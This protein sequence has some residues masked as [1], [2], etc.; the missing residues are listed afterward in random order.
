MSHFVGFIIRIYVYYFICTLLLSKQRNPL[1]KIGATKYGGKKIEHFD[2]IGAF[3]LLFPFLIGSKWIWCAL[4]FIDTFCI[5]K[6][7][8][9]VAVEDYKPTKKKKL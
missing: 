9:S 5:Y 1:N 3:L 6:P 7:S 2:F 8:R 4:W